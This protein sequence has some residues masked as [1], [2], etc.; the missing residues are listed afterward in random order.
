MHVTSVVRLRITP[1]ATPMAL[2]FDRLN[3]LIIA[4]NHIFH[5]TVPPSFDVHSTGDT[6]DTHTYAIIG[7][8]LPIPTFSQ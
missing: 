2:M 4:D 7:Q 5:F 1:H 3:G 8:S 6:P